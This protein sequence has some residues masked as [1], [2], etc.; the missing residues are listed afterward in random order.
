MIQESLGRGK[1]QEMK[2]ENGLLILNYHE[3]SRL[4]FVLLANKAT[5]SLR[6]ALD[7]FTK[8]FIET[9]GVSEFDGGDVS[10][11]IGANKIVAEV[12]A[13]IPE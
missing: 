3:K 1:I 10:K 6:Q 2:L 13:F 5:K 7:Y 4:V 9:Y 11:Y 12:F 8:K